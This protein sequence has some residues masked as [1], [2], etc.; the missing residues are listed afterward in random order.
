M[1]DNT[2]GVVN[3]LVTASMLVIL[4]I[5]CQKTPEPKTLNIQ[6]I[7]QDLVR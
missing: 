4:L 6:P 1:L 7:Q 2:K 5:A 3:R